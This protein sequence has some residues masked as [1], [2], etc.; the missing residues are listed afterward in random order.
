MF[1]IEIESL[2]WV[3]WLLCDTTDVV[4][5][6]LDIAFVAPGS[7]PRV[8]DEEVF[9]SV[10]S[11]VSDGKDSVVEWDTSALLAGDNT[12]LVVDEDWV[13]GFDGNGDRSVDEC[14]LEV[15]TSLITLDIDDSGNF[16]DSL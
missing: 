3:D 14:G 1:V 6:N 8:L 16:S 4:D 12:R 5:S 2:S 13:V 15:V 10:L 9:G 11:A 7:S